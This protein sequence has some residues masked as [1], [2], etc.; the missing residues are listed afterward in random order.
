[1]KYNAEQGTLVRESFDESTNTLTLSVF[2]AEDSS[3]ITNYTFHF[4]DECLHY[5]SLFVTTEG[6]LPADHMQMDSLKYEVIGN[7]DEFLCQCDVLN[8]KVLKS[9]YDDSTSI[10]TIVVTDTF[11]I[12]N[13]EY[14]IHFRPVDGVDDF[15][16]DQV[17]LYVT[18]KTICVDGAT[19]PISVYDLLGTLVGISRGE[20]ARIPVRQTGVYVVKA[21]G[22]AAKVAVK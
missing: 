19:E 16:G 4:I 8:G 6:G 9:E 11:G 7:Y 2:H 3:H 15:L 12:N 13:T 5:P 17:N 18:D 21:G 20:E 10:W 1:M 14:H 22:K